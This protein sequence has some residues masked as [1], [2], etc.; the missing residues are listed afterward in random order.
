MAQLT[1]WAVRMKIIEH[2][3]EVM[4]KF[5]TCYACDGLRESI[6]HAPPQCFFP[7]DKDASGRYIY[8]TDLIRVPSCAK[9]NGTKS[10][11]DQY[12]LWHIAPLA[13]TNSVAQRLEP[14]L[15][16]QMEHDVEERGGKFLARIAGEFTEQ[17]AIHLKGNADPLRMQRFIRL[18]ARAV[19]FW[20]TFEKLMLPLKVVTIGNDFRDPEM[21]ATL[22]RKEAFF[23]SRLSDAK[24]LGANPMVFNYSIAEITHEQVTLVRLVFFDSV[25]FW[26]YFHPDV[27]RAQQGA[28]DN[29][30]DAHF[31]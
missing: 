1:R 18:C 24:V 3:V 11:D 30:D 26:T 22:K 6:E 4:R 31:D 29:P 7:E 20:E 21:T 19:Y 16:R 12:A 14:K 2:R 17:D 27:K 13:G 23:E 9:H 8:Q 15:R 10:R 5:P 28:T 25:K